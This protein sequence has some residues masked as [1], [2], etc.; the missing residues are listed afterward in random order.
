MI[1]NTSKFLKSEK[2]NKAT[3][4]SGVP[5]FSGVIYKDG[6]YQNKTR[7][8]RLPFDYAE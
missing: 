5:F 1:N 2:L 7:I 6:N 3:G 8:F 4:T